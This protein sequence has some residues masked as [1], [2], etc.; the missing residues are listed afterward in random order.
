MSAALEFL[1]FGGSVCIAAVILGSV[2]LLF[3][4]P[5]FTPDSDED[6]DEQ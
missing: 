1:L 2:L 3:P 4:D 5:D 6:E